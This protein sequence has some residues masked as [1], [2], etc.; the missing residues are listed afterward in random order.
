M[1]KLLLFQLIFFLAVFVQAQKIKEVKIGDQIWM[2]NDLNVSKFRNGDLITHAKTAE[3]WKKAGEEGKPAWCYYD[4]NPKLGNPKKNGYK[5]YNFYAVSDPRGLA[6]LGWHIP[7]MNEWEILFNYLGGR[8]I[9]GKKL[10]STKVWGEN[11]VATNE[12]GFSSLPTGTRYLSGWEMEG[13]DYW[14]VN[15]NQSEGFGYDIFISFGQN[16]V[17]GGNLLDNPFLGLAV[18]CVKD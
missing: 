4:N 3:E 2:Q 1:K 7:T 17:Q 8:T 11:E 16:L 12:S 9:A 18:R 14:S 6:P 5:L 10:K 13:A 15:D